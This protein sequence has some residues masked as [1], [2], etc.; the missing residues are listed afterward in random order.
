MGSN[1]KNTPVLQK[2]CLTG[3][4]N[5]GRIEEKRRHKWYSKKEKNSVSPLGE[6]V[7]ISYYSNGFILVSIKK[8]HSQGGSAK[9]MK[10]KWKSPSCQLVFVLLFV[11][12]GHDIHA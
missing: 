9:Y 8:L 5:E 11:H 6:T 12:V 2:T 10:L 4:D 7:L 3:S 1:A